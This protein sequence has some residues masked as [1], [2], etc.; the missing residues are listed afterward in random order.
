MSWYSNLERSLVFQLALCW[1]SHHDN[2]LLTGGGWWIYFRWRLLIRFETLLVLLSTVRSHLIP[3]QYYHHDARFMFKSS[4]FH[5]N[6]CYGGLP[7]WKSPR[8]GVRLKYSQYGIHHRMFLAEEALQVIDQR[9]RRYIR[10]EFYYD[11]AE[12]F[13]YETSADEQ[14]EPVDVS[15][16]PLDKL[17]CHFNSVCAFQSI[18][19]ARRTGRALESFKSVYA[20]YAFTVALAEQCG[21]LM[22]L[23]PPELTSGAFLSNAFEACEVPC[24]VDTGCSHSVTPFASDFVS[25]ITYVYNKTLGGLKD[26]DEVSIIGYGWVEWTV[27]DVFG[28]TAVVR[29]QAYLIPEGR[30]RLFSSQSYFQE[31]QAGS[32]FQDHEKVVFTTAYAQALV[33]NYEPSCNLP[34]MFQDCEKQIG[35]TGQQ[36]QYLSTSDEIDQVSRLLQDNYNLNQ[37]MKQL[38][39][40]HYRL[41]HAGYQW[42]QDLMKRRKGNIGEQ[43][44]P[45]IISDTT[46]GAHKCAHPTCPAC[47]LAKAHR[48]SSKAQ[49]TSNKSDMEMAIRRNNLQPGECFSVDQ[50][51]SRTPGRLPGTKGKESLHARYTGGTIFVDHSSGFIFLRNQVSLGIEETLLAKHQL[52]RYADQFGVKVLSFRADNKPFDADKFVEDLLVQNQTITY[53]G[54]GAHFQNG[55]AERA[56]QT[57]T[58]W[59]LAMM[60]HHMLHWPDQFDETL[61]PFALE[62]AVLLWNHMP[63]SNSGLSPLELFTRTVLGS[64]EVIQRARVW[65]SPCYVLSP[66]LQ[67]AKK[68]PKWKRKSRLGVY[69]GGSSQHSPTVGRILNLKTGHISPQFHVVYDELFTSVQGKLEKEYFDP[70]IWSNMIQLKGLELSLDASDLDDGDSCYQ[71]LY[72]DFVNPDLDADVAEDVTPPPL[73]ARFQ[74]L[75]PD[76]EADVDMELLSQ[77]DP[78]VVSSVPKGDDDDK[79]D[80]ESDDDDSVGTSESEGDDDDGMVTRSGRRLKAKDKAIAS[81]RFAG[82]YYTSKTSHVPR[83]CNTP[84]VYQYR[85]GGHP[86]QKI[87]AATLQNQRI[88]SL[89]WSST[90]SDLKSL[91]SKRALIQMLKTY[92]PQEETVEEF[93]PMALAARAN[94]ASTPTWSEAMNG[95]NEEGFWDACKL[96][97]ET[98]E[99]M[100]VWDV[101]DKEPWMRVVKS[102]WAFKIKHYPS[103]LV[104]KLKA[105]FC[106]RGDTQIKGVDWF[107]NYAPVVQWTTVRLLLVMTAQLGLA[108]RQADL[109]SAFVHADI[110]RHPNYDKMSPEE[111]RRS[112][113]YLDMPRGFRDDGK[114]LRLKKSLYGDCAAPRNYYKWLVG[115]MEEVGLHQMTDVDPCLFISDFCICVCY[116]DDLL[117]YSDSA[118]NITDVLKAL[119]KLDVQLEEEDDVAGFL[120]VQIQNHDGHME[121]TQV[122]LTK[123]IIEALKIDDLPS[124]ATPATEVLGKDED[125]EGPDCS[126]NYAS[127]VGM[128]GYLYGHSR[129]ELA[130]SFS[131]VA[132]FSFSPKRSHELALIRIGQYLKGTVDKGLIMKPMSTGKLKMDV[133]VD[134]DFMGIYGKEERADPDNVKS[135]AGHVICLNDCPIV[136]SSKLQDAICLSTMMSEYYALSTSMREVIPLRRTVKAVAHGCKLLDH[137]ETTFMT[138]VWEDNVGALT[139]AQ[140]DPGRNTPRSKFYDVKVH[141]FRSHLSNDED[142]GIVVRKID[143]KDQI[144]D[145]FTKPL[146]REPFERLRKLLMGW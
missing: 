93:S 37:H 26:E 52:E 54:V 38:L 89:T 71:D 127:V 42:V 63:R 70:T 55:V 137:C 19:V 131:Q 95:P 11:A 132:R 8:T 50:Y 115:K 133:Y 2:V 139:L 136:W 20:D 67:D 14:V 118:D 123:R 122:G 32:L 3:P 1:Y 64:N 49:T 28:R 101:V 40:W 107:E 48:I 12:D 66:K 69:L 41:G 85:A 104:R 105:R 29:T 77:P 43:A 102:T 36:A 86:S 23:A 56:L 88:Q 79:A 33:F 27:R 146:A 91:S 112:L 6:W 68:L 13:W 138:T 100:K 74:D 59:A 7:S 17:K 80:E 140:L 22:K 119:R 121:L 98:L 114:V 5:V 47:R 57:I 94:D 108:T 46:G 142:D 126:F 113:V 18:S 96:E 116:V 124:V 128:I 117:L 65:G 78:P 60:M 143:T 34:L 45:A 39:L 81:P 53:S 44:E 10:Q 16:T 87:R 15:V 51:I 58:S 92:D 73:D 99:K 135:R 21:L 31:N 111:Q 84:Q 82:T 72:E 30:I 35:L 90:I 83:K 4:P 76:L 125:G 24:V 97:I 61:W 75:Y 129:P 141:W 106:V 110:H 120:G 109:T 145:I 144:A 134:A 9:S 25:E 103:G 130:F 62:H